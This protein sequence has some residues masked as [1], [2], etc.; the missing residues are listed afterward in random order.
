M[1]RTI[2]DEMSSEV[3]VS[4]G[5]EAS[6]EPVNWSPGGLPDDPDEIIGWLMDPLHRGELYPLYHQL[7][8]VAPVHK[9]RPEMLNGSWIVSTYA[10]V[11]ALVK[12]PVAVNDPAVVDHAFNHGDGAFYS[13]MKNT[14]IFLESQSHERIRKLVV[15]AFTPRA[16]ARWA[17]IAAGVAN[18]LCDAVQDDG[19]ME[20]VQQFNYEL[21][22]NVIAHILGVPE[23][24]FALMKQ[25]AWDFARAG[26]KIVDP[27]VARRGDDAARGF[28]AYFEDLAERR[29]ANPTEDLISALVQVEESGDRLS[30]TELVANCVLLMQAGHETTQD[31][32]GNAMVALFRSPE[33]LS[34]LRERAELT[35]PAVEEFLRFDGSVQINHRLLRAGLTMSGIE[36]PEGDMVYALLGAANRDPAAFEDPDRL[37]ITRRPAHHL[38]FGFGTY[39]CVGASLART[40]AEV[41]IRTLLDRFPGIRPASDTFEWRDTLTLRGPRRIDVE[42]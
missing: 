30:H 22:F 1:T 38:A 41:G 39:Y 24:D 5:I 26:E 34:Q 12:S 21:P 28:T 20:L 35:K 29:R 17:P 19:G 9:C 11:D 4:K 6:Y 42:W 27:E 23:P 7:R 31:L 15:R 33:Q 40:E 13:V 8:R 2:G 25:L 32:L 18:E 36:V 37:D 16:I 10:D 14:M 3:V